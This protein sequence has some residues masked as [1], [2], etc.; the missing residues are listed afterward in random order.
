MLGLQVARVAAEEEPGIGG[1]RECDEDRDDVLAE[2]PA[3]V[4]QQQGD[5]A[6][7]HEAHRQVESADQTD[8]VHVIVIIALLC[9][10]C[11]ADTGSQTILHLET[12][13]RIPNGHGFA[14]Y[15]SSRNRVKNA[16]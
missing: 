4:H 6:D 10:L 11:R 9:L 14:D 12:E 3:P 16:E 8:E 1:E 2:R 13:S 5:T 7:V 15:S